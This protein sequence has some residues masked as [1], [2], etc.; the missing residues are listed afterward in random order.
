MTDW[1]C[2]YNKTEWAPLGLEMFTCLRSFCWIGIRS[3]LE[4]QLLQ[5]CLE[6][7][8]GNL[9]ELILDLTS[10]EKASQS[11]LEDIDPDDHKALQEGRS[12]NFFASCILGVAPQGRRLFFPNLRILSF[13]CVSFETMAAELACALNL[14]HLHTL[15][16]WNCQSSIEALEQVARSN[17]PVRLTSLELSLSHDEVDLS[18]ESNYSK[19]HYFLTRFQG[20]VNL[21]LRLPGPAN[22]SL[23][24]K[25]VANH[26]TTL[27]RLVMAE[28]KLKPNDFDFECDGDINWTSP[29]RSMI[30]SLNL[31]CLGISN[32]LDYLVRRSF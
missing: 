1:C 16:L 29:V 30:L 5:D 32:E 6:S 4:F 8:R 2:G 17:S 23:I 27:K 12:P 28:R 10:W 25:G 3:R 26:R 15:T 19:L 18:L 9:R 20:L 11:W 22:W 21:Y 14:A 13:L 31:Q 24:G 7:N